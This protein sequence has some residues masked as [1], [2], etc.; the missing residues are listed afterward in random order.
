MYNVNQMIIYYRFQMTEVSLDAAVSEAK[1]K[2]PEET[3]EALDTWIVEAVEVFQKNEG[4]GG[5]LETILCHLITNQAPSLLLKKV[6]IVESFKYLFLTAE[7]IVSGSDVLDDDVEAAVVECS[8]DFAASYLR[9]GDQT[10]EKLSTLEEKINAN[11]TDLSEKL[12]TQCDLTFHYAK[13][14]N[15]DQ[16]KQSL[17]KETE[18]LLQ[19]ENYEKAYLKIIKFKLFCLGGLRTFSAHTARID[20]DQFEEVFSV[21]KKI[22]EKFLDF[23][24]DDGG[25]F[26]SEVQ[27]DREEADIIVNLKGQKGF[28]DGKF[29]VNDL[30]SGLRLAQ[31][32]GGVIFLE[33]G[34]YQTETFHHV[35][36]NSSDKTITVL[37]SSTNE[38]SVHGTLKID[39]ENKIIFKRLKLEIGDSADSKDA[40]FLTKGGAVFEDCL[41]ESPV[42]SLFYVL[43]RCQ[44]TLVRCVVDGLESC[45]RCLSL[46]GAEVRLELEDCWVR[47]LLSLLT[48]LQEEKVEKIN[49]RLAGCELE[50]VQSVIS[51]AVLSVETVRVEE[52]N[53]GLVLY[54]QDVE[55]VGIKLTSEE[56]SGQSRVVSNNNYLNFKHIDGK[57]FDVQNIRDVDLRRTV[58]V[59]DENIDRKLAICEAVKSQQVDVLSLENIFIRGFRFGV[60]L[61]RTKTANIRLCT[62]EKCAIGVNLSQAS[63]PSAVRGKIR[64]E[65][66]ELKFTYYGI[67]GSDTGARLTILNNKFLDIPKPLL[68]CREIIAGL[69]EES[70][71]YLLT[72]EYTSAQDFSTLEKELNL[73]LATSENLPHRAAYERDD[74]QLV[75]KYDNLGFSNE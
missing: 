57:G 39:S 32:K 45:Q 13:T 12:Q 18:F 64:V 41:I 15:V 63:P 35:K 56:K 66:C 1:T 38:C 46:S 21:R 37:G 9:L 30:A 6:S 65:D 75:Y 3:T 36:L 49:I 70:C 67:F 19:I 29:Y 34:D 20:L 23:L 68:L 48:V 58:I 54:D 25:G 28:Q 2:L 60:N 44:L 11:K 26:S 5:P 71:Q 72:K 61:S 24:D 17:I 69:S 43:E 27:R 10:E 4:N 51:G 55:S 33:A 40:I 42:N 50:G 74:V 62:L 59:T 53:L 16:F 73:Y 22:F 14:R 8:K 31:N 7:K 52:T 47:D